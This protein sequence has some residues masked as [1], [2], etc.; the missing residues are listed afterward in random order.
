MQNVWV[1][2]DE[3]QRGAFVAEIICF[4]ARGWIYSAAA[5]YFCTSILIFS[6]D[7][8][9]QLQRAYLFECLEVTFNN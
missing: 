7:S 9:R 2:G 8:S 3:Y 4:L 1:M 5:R 6:P